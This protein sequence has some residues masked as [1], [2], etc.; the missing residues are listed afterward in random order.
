MFGFFVL[1]LVSGFGL[2]FGCVLGFRVF[3]RLLIVLLVFF[4]LSHV[5]VIGGCYVILLVFVYLCFCCLLG[6][7]DWMFVCLV[8]W[9][10]WQRLFV[11]FVCGFGALMRAA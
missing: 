9:V 2:L 3:G 1:C 6:L 5:F 10:G 11:C 8:I 7:L 4:S